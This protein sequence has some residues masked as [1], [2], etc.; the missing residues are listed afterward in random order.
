[1]GGRE[2]ERGRGGREGAELSCAAPEGTGDGGGGRRPR[3]LARWRRS[4][5]QWR[6]ERGHATIRG[7]ARHD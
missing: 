3:T 4:R 7:R 6:L 2:R 1:M 5:A